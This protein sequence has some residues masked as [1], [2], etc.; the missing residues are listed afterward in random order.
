VIVKGDGICITAGDPPSVVYPGDPF[1]PGTALERSQYLGHRGNVPYYA[2]EIGREDP[3]P[4]GTT[5]SGIRDLFTRVPDEDLAL[6]AFAVRIIDFDRKTRFCGRCGCE[7]RQLRTERSKECSSCGLVTYPRL[8]PAIIVLIQR[9]DRILLARSPR[10]PPDLFG[11]IAGFVESGEN[12][13]EALQREVREETGLSV[14]DIR[15]FGSEPWPFPDSL[16]LGFI[17]D[18]AG[19]E[20]VIDKNEIEY[21]AWFDREH[22]PRIPEKLSISR[23]LIDWWVEKGRR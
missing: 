6:A 22:L 5:S 20:L 17:A 8:S 4:E 10:F 23:A 11:L 2:G 3:V 1:R 14:K 16:M 15:Y 12:L 9:D 18:Y 19:G 7:T 13:E 21:A